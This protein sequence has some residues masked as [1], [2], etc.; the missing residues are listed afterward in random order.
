MY[1]MPKQCALPLALKC[2]WN[3][4]FSTTG[5]AS[6]QRYHAF[7]LPFAQG[8]ICPTLHFE[9]VS[10]HE[11]KARAS[12]AFFHLIASDSSVARTSIIYKTWDFHL[13][14]DLNSSLL[15]ARWIAFLRSFCFPLRLCNQDS[16]PLKALAVWIFV[17]R[18]IMEDSFLLLLWTRAS[19]STQWFYARCRCLLRIRWMHVRTKATWSWGIP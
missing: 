8:N 12:S 16:H 3:P 6:T 4:Y 17:H 2:A 10:D 13:L 15:C 14:Q 11:V 1:S 19:V 5:I 18:T 7:V 9:T